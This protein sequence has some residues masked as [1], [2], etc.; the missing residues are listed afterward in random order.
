MAERMG[1]VPDHLARAVNGKDVIWLYAA[2]PEDVVAAERL[3]VE[4]ISEF[5]GFVVAVSTDGD[6][7]QK[8]AC[9]RFD[10]AVPVFTMPVDMG[11]AM[12]RY[13]NT[14]QPKL[15]VLMD[16]K[17]PT[18][19]LG[20]CDSCCIPTVVMNVRI[21]GSRWFA[22]VSKGLLS[23][24]SLFLTQGNESVQPLVE[25]GVR[26]E[27]IRLVGDM[28]W[29]APRIKQL[30][31]ASRLGRYLPQVGEVILCAGTCEGEESTILTAW[32]LL[33]MTGHMAVMILSPAQSER[34]GE[35]T[36]LVSNSGF[37]AIRI[38]DWMKAPFQIN[39]GDV[40]VLDRIG[41]L[42]AVYKV[43]TVAFLGGSLV[44]RGGISPVES[45]RFGVPALIGPH[46]ENF[47]VE[48]D[49]MRQADAIYM[50]EKSNLVEKLHT[51]MSRGRAV[52]Q[53]ARDFHQVQG[54][55]SVRTA[56]ELKEVVLADARALGHVPFGERARAERGLLRQSA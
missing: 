51:A 20:E 1:Q 14:L 43:A 2:S 41:E 9:E 23:K 54:G 21:T 8:E 4:L 33:R 13:L 35:V 42:A 34:F 27:R 29:D 32:K 47:R 25:M 36:R 50:V 53:R 55:A 26:P 19:L 7:G 24:I 12:R 11:F 16:G 18:G 48:V 52:G 39:H 30:E 49:G 10:E 46:Y 38:S 28:R 45:A 56:A 15:V 44:A 40:L 37:T 31:V 3:V 6:D 5:P 17:L 22:G